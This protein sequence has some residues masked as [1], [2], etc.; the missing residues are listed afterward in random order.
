[1]SEYSWAVER[2]DEPDGG[3]FL[4]WVSDQGTPLQSRF[5]TDW[6]PTE[7]DVDYMFERVRREPVVLES[8]EVAERLA[9]EGLAD[10]EVRTLVGAEES[11]LAAWRPFALADRLIAR[12]TAVT[13]HGA[14]SDVVI[15]HSAWTSLKALPRLIVV[16]APTPFEMLIVVRRDADRWRL[17]VGDRPRRGQSLRTWLAGHH[18]R[19]TALAEQPQ[20]HPGWTLSGIRS[21]G[22]A[23]RLIVAV[24]TL[25]ATRSMADV[26]VEQ[27]L[28]CSVIGPLRVQ[29]VAPSVAGDRA[30]FSTI[31]GA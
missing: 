31:C 13:V 8:R 27:T 4:H 3:P 10:A 20:R 21:V 24:E 6:P 30:A 5:V 28:E 23:E 22:A 19:F 15:A 18:V 29:I 11:L 9:A 14:R 2:V 17:D 25:S 1:M 12:S 16:E 26:R 7:E